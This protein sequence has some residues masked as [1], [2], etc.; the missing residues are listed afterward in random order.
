[1]AP[2]STDSGRSRTS[3][4]SMN[5]EPGGGSYSRASSEMSVDFP[6]PVTP[7]SATVSPAAIVADTWLSTR[8]S[9]NANTRSRNSIAP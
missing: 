6:E 7:T 2:R 1:M 5:T 8:A 4:P 3:T 9:P